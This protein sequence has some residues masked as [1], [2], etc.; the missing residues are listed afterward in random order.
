MV[1]ECFKTL[2]LC[3]GKCEEFDIINFP[4]L[5]ELARSVIHAASTEIQC[6]LYAE[7]EAC[8]KTKEKKLESK[9][10]LYIHV[11]KKWYARNCKKWRKTNWEAKIMEFKSCNWILALSLMGSYLKFCKKLSSWEDYV[12]N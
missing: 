7:F 11:I 8:M 1:S 9:S 6:H 5:G 2:F 10:V 12:L 4:K 3:V